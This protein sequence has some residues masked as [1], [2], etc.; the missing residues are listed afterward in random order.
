MFHDEACFHLNGYITDITPCVGCRI[1]IMM[2]LTLISKLIPRI[3]V[4]CEI[5][6]NTLGTRIPGSRSEHR[7]ISPVVE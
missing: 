5:Q 7:M 4:W 1:I 2:Q 6:G 3:R